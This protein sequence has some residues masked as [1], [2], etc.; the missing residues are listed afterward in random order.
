MPLEIRHVPPSA[1]GDE[2]LED[3]VCPARHVVD[4]LVLVAH[5]DAWQAVA[6]DGELRNP[7][8]GEL[9]QHLLECLRC[10]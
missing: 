8:S 7:R 4:G 3:G 5:L 1:G 2:H 6:G 10:V 9:A